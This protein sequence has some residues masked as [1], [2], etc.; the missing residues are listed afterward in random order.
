LALDVQMSA[1]ERQALIS[2][3]ALLLDF[4]A[5]RRFRGCKPNHI[6]S[7]FPAVDGFCKSH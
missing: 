5:V 7:I 1:R 6:N 4:V 2:C 3:A